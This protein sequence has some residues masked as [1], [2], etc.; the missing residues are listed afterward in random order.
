[1]KMRKR[2]I[3]EV[4]ENRMHELSGII[5]ENAHKIMNLGFDEDI[6]NYLANI[7][8]KRGMFL[9]DSLTR[10]YIKDKG[11]SG[12]EGQGV[13]QI[14]PSIDQKDLFNYMKSRENEMQM[15]SDWVKASG[16]QVDLRSFSDFNDVLAAAEK[17]MSQKEQINFP[18]SIE[19]LLLNADYNFGKDLGIIALKNLVLVEYPWED[20]DSLS[21]GEMLDMVDEKDLHS[22]IVDSEHE[23]NLIVDWI[24]SLGRQE[25]EGELTSDFISSKNFHSLGEV[26]DI[27]KSWHD[28]IERN[29]TGKVD[30]PYDG[31][32]V[33]RYEDG[34]Y[35]IDLLTN[36]SEQES[37]AMGHCGRDGQ[38]TTLISLRDKK[39]D[40]HITIA[41]NE[42][43]NNVTQVKGRG[44]EK[45]SGTGS[46]KYMKYVNDFLI[47]LVKNSKLSTFKW[48]YGPDLNK[49]E[50]E[51]ILSHLSAKDKFKMIKMQSPKLGTYGRNLR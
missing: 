50:T 9:A 16:G 13:K 25:D 2:I 43:I 12:L 44:N 26:F 47:D 3:S 33:K 34:Y 35:W 22:I 39:G 38:A 30:N 32:I 51:N 46:V 48:S 8:K 11:I 40:P 15:I 28:T 4:F 17:D 19:T 10:Q 24:K 14:L 20:V 37:K 31:K 6:S 5:Q 23:I 7:D 45:P 42:R 41:Y 1:M 49:E 18:S 27:A 29:Y 36:N 21:V